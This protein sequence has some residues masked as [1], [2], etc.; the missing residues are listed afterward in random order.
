MI[1]D[2]SHNNGTAAANGLSLVGISK[3]RLR[4]W[5]DGSG[6][7]ERGVYIDDLVMTTISAASGQ[8]YED[9]V[10]SQSVT[11]TNA[12]TVDQEIAK[13]E[14]ETSGGT[15]NQYSLKSLDLTIAEFAH[16]DKVTIYSTGTDGS[17]STATPVATLTAPQAANQTLTLTT[18]LP[19]LSGLNNLWV[20]YDVSI[21]AP[22]ETDLDVSCTSI[23]INN[24]ADESQTPSVPDPIGAIEVTGIIWDFVNQTDTATQGTVDNG[25]IID[26]EGT[27]FTS[28]G[29]AG[30][31]EGK[32]YLQTTYQNSDNNQDYY[33]PDGGAGVPPADNVNVVSLQWPIPANAIVSE[34]S[35]DF[36]TANNAK[37]LYLQL[38]AYDG[39]AWNQIDFTDGVHYL[40]GGIIRDGTISADTSATATMNI[41]GYVAFRLR[42]WSFSDDPAAVVGGY[43]DNLVMKYENPSAQTVVSFDLEQGYQAAAA[44]E[45]TVDLPTLAMN[46]EM[47]GVVNKDSLTNLNL[48]VEDTNNRITQVK[49]YGPSASNV[50]DYDALDTP[51]YAGTVNNGVNNIA[52]TST[53]LE[54]GDNYFWITTSIENTGTNDEI[55]DINV[56]A[57]TLAINNNVAPT[58]IDPDGDIKLKTYTLPIKNLGRVITS[59]NEPR[60]N[61][62]AVYSNDVYL[63]GFENDFTDASIVDLDGNGSPDWRD[64]SSLPFDVSGV[65]TSADDQ[66]IRADVADTLIRNK[67]FG[68]TGNTSYTFEVYMKIAGESSGIYD[69]SWGFIGNNGYNNTNSSMLLISDDRMQLGTE[70]I[71]T[72]D[73][74]R[75]LIYFRF[76]YEASGNNDATGD[77]YIYRNTEL[78][79]VYRNRTGS[80]GNSWFG[81]WGGNL[82]GNYTISHIAFT[83]GT[84]A[85]DPNTSP[86]VG[87]ELTQTGNELIWTIEDEIGVKEYQVIDSTTGEVIAVIA[88][89]GRSMYTT[90]VPDGVTAK[91]VVVDESGLSKFFIL[92]MEINE[93]YPMI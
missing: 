81:D 8:V 82:G 35:L 62:T 65:V 29:A 20:A 2:G 6:T 5:S 31:A 14:I 33:N 27:N 3:M 11:E 48:T 56:N 37:W 30:H 32:F 10:C 74:T 46:L 72:E 13:I 58:A 64:T 28:Y 16:V 22:L 61:Q 52:V 85:P 54:H 76:V 50:F 19:L 42:C 1:K 77:I 49:I 80:S 89:D 91:L 88:A 59:A 75:E 43:I 26:I 63:Y 60:N 21:S 83:L 79:G 69:A 23:V 36:E 66:I 4:A 67:D 17:F 39:S 53:Q 9:T 18:P 40:E 92:R 84:H 87:L 73:N 57:A 45:T 90:T 71:S 25:A 70:V 51:I 86:V 68:H 78:L 24:G 7:G 12:G 15:Q 47:L 93:P 41:T 38:E 55:L 44:G 34:V